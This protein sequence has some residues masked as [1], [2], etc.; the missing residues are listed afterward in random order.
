MTSRRHS[1][2]PRVRAVVNFQQTVSRQVRVL[3]C[4][5]ERHMSQHLLNRSQVCSLVEEVGSERMA[6]RMGAN[7]ARG[8]TTGMF[9]HDPI[10]AARG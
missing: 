2:R 9:H 4:R 10:H 6:E 1:P 5:G 7:R 8:E 3:L